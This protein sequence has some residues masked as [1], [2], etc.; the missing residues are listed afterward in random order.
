MT[1]SPYLVEK[2]EAEK[3][4]IYWPQIEKE[5]D[6]VP[7]IWSNRWT[8]EAIRDLTL[9]GRFQCWASGDENTV[10]GVV[11]SQI[12]C[13]PAASVFQVLLAFGVGLP[14]TV[15]AINATCEKFATFNGCSEME[16]IGR[17]GWEPKL[18]NVGFKRT[19]MVW[20]RK[21]QPIRMN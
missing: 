11:F 10:I 17:D 8:K 13:Y 12:A 15:D 4:L 2:L 5:L 9:E 21:L 7:H 16:V 19:S 14:E 1:P 3:F 18:R 6:T 20:T